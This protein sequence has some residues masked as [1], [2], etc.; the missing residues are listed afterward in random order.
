MKYKD[1]EIGGIPTENYNMKL[2]KK[3]RKFYY[4]AEKKTKI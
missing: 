1:S 4:E 2:N 3:K